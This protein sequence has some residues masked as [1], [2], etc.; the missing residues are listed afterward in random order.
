ML[1]AFLF[2]SLTAVLARAQQLDPKTCANN[3]CKIIAYGRAPDLHFPDFV[4]FRSRLIAFYGE[5]FSPAWLTDEGPT[6]R[7]LTMIGLLKAADRKGLKAEDYNSDLWDDQIAHLDRSQFDVC[8]TVSLMRYLADLHFGKANPGFYHLEPQY[9]DFD[10]P[11]FL[12]EKLMGSSDPEALVSA[13]VEPPYSAYKRAEKALADYLVLAGEPEVKLADL[14]A[15]VEPGKRYAEVALVAQRLHQ[16]G[17][18]PK[19]KVIGENQRLYKGALVQAVKRFQARHG[20]EPDG[21]LGRATIEQLNVPL[22]HRVEQLRLTLD[23][24]AGCRTLFLTR[25][26]WSI[27]PNSRC[28]H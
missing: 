25:R 5:S 9:K 10:I 22:A 3:I 17:D 11:G 21:R 2:V 24:G 1:K 15:T 7:A 6:S 20:L 8:L 12:R 4:D 16:L 13:E 28:A 18:L 23:A 14:T 27:F 26:S 19:D